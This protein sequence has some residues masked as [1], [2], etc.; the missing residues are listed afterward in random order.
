MPSKDVEGPT[1][2]DAGRSDVRKRRSLDRRRTDGG[3]RERLAVGA[4]DNDACGGEDIG[5]GA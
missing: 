5:I 3:E 4:V 2:S 1:T